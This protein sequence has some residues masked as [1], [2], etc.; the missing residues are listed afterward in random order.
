MLLV[1]ESSPWKLLP[2]NV[3][4]EVE[5]ELTS[6]DDIPADLLE[7]EYNRTSNSHSRPFRNEKKN[8]VQ[9]RFEGPGVTPQRTGP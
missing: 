3:V 9:H 2:G 4:R 1:A 5:V 7:F 8:E 6:T